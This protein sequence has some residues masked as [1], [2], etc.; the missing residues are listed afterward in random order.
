MD[1]AS[2]PE[3]IR[4]P[5]LGG[6][7]VLMI[8]TVVLDASSDLALIVGP[9]VPPLVGGLIWRF[10][11]LPW[12]DVLSWTVPLALWIAV[13]WMILPGLGLLGSIAGGVSVAAW[14]SAFIF[15][16]RVARW[17]YRAVLRKPYPWPAAT[18]SARDIHER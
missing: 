14:I 12:I 4:M 13:A 15:W 18:R 10:D 11:R 2:W 16:T 5:I 9:I 1:P 3:P 17:W 8:A 6:L 7:I